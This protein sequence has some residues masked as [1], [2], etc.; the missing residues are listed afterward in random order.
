MGESLYC[1][2]G[3]EILQF[4]FWPRNPETE[5][6]SCLLKTVQACDSFRCGVDEV[7]RVVSVLRRISVPCPCEAVAYAMEL[8]FTHDILH[9]CSPYVFQLIVHFPGPVHFPVRIF[10]IYLLFSTREIWSCVFQFCIYS[11]GILCHYNYVHPI[12]TLTLIF[13]SF[14]PCGTVL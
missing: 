14:R 10:S 13:H 2:T 5:F 4:C 7:S 3:T 8:Y 6:G 12:N 11:T 9:A 1:D